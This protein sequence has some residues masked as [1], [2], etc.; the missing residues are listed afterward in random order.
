MGKDKKKKKENKK[1]QL[2]GAFIVSTSREDIAI[3]LEIADRLNMGFHELSDEECR[4]LV[5]PEKKIMSKKKEKEKTTE[6]S[7][8]QT[9]PAKKVKTVPVKKKS[10]TRR[11]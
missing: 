3:L 6:K 8:V 9:T 7:V 10:V 2:T 5:Q 1:Q 11:K 4:Y